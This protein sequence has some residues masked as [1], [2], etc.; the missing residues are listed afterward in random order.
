MRPGSL[1]PLL[2][3]LAMAFFGF[4]VYATLGTTKSRTVTHPSPP[5]PPS[6]APAAALPGTMYLV[7]AG[8]L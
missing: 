1:R 3:V 8:T 2:A 5:P 4:G 7:Q 6:A